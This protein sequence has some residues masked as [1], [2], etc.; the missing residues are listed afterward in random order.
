ME[1]SITLIPDDNHPVDKIPLTEADVST[2]K[3]CGDC[4]A[5]CTIMR[6]GALNKRDYTPCQHICSKGCAIYSEKP[7]ECSTWQCAWKSD[8]ID[9][10]ERR[11]P[12]NLGVMFE[13][14]SVG[15][16]CFLWVYEVWPGALKD[17][18]VSYLLKR[19]GEKESIVVCQHGSMDVFANQRVMDFLIKHGR[20]GTDAAI[21]PRQPV[22]DKHGQ[23]IGTLVVER[24]NH[25]FIFKTVSP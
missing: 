12:D 4:T 11:R 20:G 22:Y 17:E 3:P 21:V 7:S 16:S 6:V 15:G 5:C 18:K 8:W 13:Y 24:R 1:S 2:A 9:G 10:D 14:R 19:I 25:A 23:V